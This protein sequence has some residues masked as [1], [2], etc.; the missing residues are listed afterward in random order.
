MFLTSKIQKFQFKKKKKITALDWFQSWSIASFYWFFKRN[1]NPFFA[2]CIRYA[3][4]SFFSTTCTLPT[5][6]FF[7]HTH[8][9]WQTVARRENANHFLIKYS[10]FS[11]FHYKPRKPKSKEFIWY[12]CKFQIKISCPNVGCT[13]IRW[14]RAETL[15]FLQHSWTFTSFFFLLSW[16]EKITREIFSSLTLR[17]C[18]ETI[19]G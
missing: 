10:F 11:A 3:K 18:E 13:G 6:F 12:G 2:S 9:P 8:V 15:S 19:T 17:D 16:L 5:F 1:Q 7:S 14:H 4:C